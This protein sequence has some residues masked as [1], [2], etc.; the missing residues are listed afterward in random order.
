MTKLTYC[1]SP[2]RESFSNTF[3]TTVSTTING[4]ATLTAGANISVTTHGNVLGKAVS[5]NDSGGFISVNWANSHVTVSMTNTVT[6]AN[7]ATLTALGT[8]AGQ[9]DVAVRRASSSSR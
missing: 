2:T 9:G 5:S 8:V 3:A 6:V 7:G 4:N 1:S